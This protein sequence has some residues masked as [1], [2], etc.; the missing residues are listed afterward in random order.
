MLRSLLLASVALAPL[1][2]ASQPAFAS[3][4]PSKPDNGQSVTCTGTDT[5]GVDRKD[6]NNVTVTVASGAT[7]TNASGTGNHVFRFNDGADFTIG[8]TVESFSDKDALNLVDDATV[9]LIGGTLKSAEG[10]GV[11]AESGL[12]LTLDEASS[13]AVGKKGVNAEGESNGY[14]L[15]SGTITAGTKGVDLGDTSVVENFGTITAGTKAIDIGDD[16]IVRNYGTIAAGTEGI[17][18]DDYG[19]V[20]NHGTISALDDA[21]NAG[22]YVTITNYGTLHSQADTLGIDFVQDAID[23]DSGTI[24]NY[25][26]ILSDDD[27]AIDFDATK[28]LTTASII[29]NSGTIKGA[30]GIIVETGY[31]DAGNLNGEEGNLGIQQVVNLDGGVIEATS[32]PALKLGAGNDL[33]SGARGSVLIG[34]TDLGL[35]DDVFS[36]S[37]GA[38]VIGDVFLGAG[39]DLLEITDTGA[40]S[41]GLFDGGLGNDVVSFVDYAS[42]DLVGLGWLESVLSLS[43]LDGFSLSLTNFET[44]SFSDATFAIAD[45][46]LPSV[47][48]P[49]PALLLISALGGFGLVRRL[50]RR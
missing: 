42:T 1:A 50:R 13:I 30:A 3:C 40:G 43:F 46:S 17:E 15:N 18:L 10:D 8:G 20:E 32:G 48:V 5:K 47:P 19:I 11:Q 31:D 27:A 38:T 6:V 45:L 23:L 25:G 34:V 26:T 21:I 2:L 36:V 44:V 28:D 37:T 4:S 29:T 24:T 33:Y 7:V 39:D 35:G 22:E 16:A 41:F 9:A 49:A 14:V 12:T